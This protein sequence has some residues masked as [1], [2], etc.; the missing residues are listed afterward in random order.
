MRIKKLRKPLKKINYSLYYSFKEKREKKVANTY[1]I[2]QQFKMLKK[3]F[4]FNIYVNEG[5]MENLFFDYYNWM[6]IFWHVVLRL[7][8][9]NYINVELHVKKFFKI[10]ILKQTIKNIFFF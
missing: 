1:L 6:K 10:Y 8:S 9:Y 7:Y 3:K 2:I 5:T 4:L